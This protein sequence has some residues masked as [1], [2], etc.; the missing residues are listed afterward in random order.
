MKKS[1]VKTCPRDKEIL[2]RFN[3]FGIDLDQCPACEGLWFDPGEL[4]AIKNNM[5][6]DVRWKDFDLRSYAER[7][8]FKHTNLVCAN[9]GSALCELL[10]DTSRI[11]L[12]F[13]VKCGGVWADKGKL[14]PILKHMHKSVDLESLDQI[15]KETL[16]KFLEIFTGRKGPWEEVKDFLAAWRLLSL[17]F[18]VGHPALAARLETARRALPF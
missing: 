7:A 3:V 14:V 12:E 1:R 11:E 5:D 4:D 16:H 13:C 17:K 8:H 15:E 9:C 2:T 6:D 10:F 18:V